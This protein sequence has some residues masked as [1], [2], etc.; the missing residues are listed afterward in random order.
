MSKP[1]DPNFAYKIA[2]GAFVVAAVITAAVVAKH[3]YDKN[4][5]HNKEA[6]QEE[7]ITKTTVVEKKDDKARGGPRRVG[8]AA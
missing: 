3:W 7:K 2:A 6:V 5:S 1:A 8:V 4:Y